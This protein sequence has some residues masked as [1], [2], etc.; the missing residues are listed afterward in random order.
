MSELKGVSLQ[1]LLGLHAGI[2]E[3]LRRRGVARSANN[4]TASVAEFLFCRA[5]SWQQAANSEKGFDATD[6][7]GKRYQIKGRR[8]HRRNKSR[9]VSAIRDLDGFDTLAAVLLDEQFRVSRAA[10]IP[11]AVVGERAKFVRH[12][13]SYKF[14]LSDDVW[15]DGRVRDVT[16]ELR[17]AKSRALDV[18]VEIG[19][20]HGGAAG[21]PRIGHPS[22][23]TGSRSG[24]A[25]RDASS[26]SNALANKHRTGSSGEC[27]RRTMERAAYRL[28]YDNI[29]DFKTVAMHVESEIKRLGIRSD[30][31]DPV[32]GMKGRTHCDMWVSMKSVSHFNLGTALEL[33]LKSYSTERGLS[34]RTETRT[35]DRP[36]TP[37]P[38]PRG[39]HARSPSR[40]YSYR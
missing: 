10:L 23:G 32:P 22:M 29:H 17:A 37:Q 11:R 13:N 30:S 39:T 16:G 20:G 27:E 26:T 25:C 3:E 7:D 12:T 1:A 24:S 2:M 34:R 8:L 6:G 18:G 15:K 4:P 38:S 40:S 19:I 33:M 28:F 14:M 21:H 31:D 35:G 5:F 9:Q 36:P